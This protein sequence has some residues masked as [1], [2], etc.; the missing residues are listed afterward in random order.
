MR[1][2]AWSRRRGLTAPVVLLA[3]SSVSHA[4]MPRFSIREV[5]YVSET[6]TN[7]LEAVS[8]F[9]VVS[10]ILGAVIQRLWNGLRNDFPRLPWLSYPKAM[11]VV[12]L[13]SLLFVLVLTMISGARELLTPGAWEK[14]GATYRLVESK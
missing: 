7:R 10:L 11:G 14:H 3:M 8:F 5:V 2:L 12:F 4:G 13:W 6:G 9:F 1:S